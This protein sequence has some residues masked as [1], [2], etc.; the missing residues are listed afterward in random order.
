MTIAAIAGI[1]LVCGIGGALLAEMSLRPPRRTLASDANARA[2]GIASRTGATVTS[3]PLVASDGVILRAWSFAPVG[4]ARGT[5]ILVHGISDNRT[6]QLGLAALLLDHMYRVL[7]IDVRA[8]G[9]SGGELASY[10]LLERGDLR[11][12]TDWVRRHHPDE[13][14][15]AFGASMGAAIVL[16]TLPEEPY[17]AAIVEAPFTTFRETAVFRLG[18]GLHVPMWLRWPLLDPFV[19][20]GLLYARLRH[21]LAL[22]SVDAVSAVARAHVPLLVIEDGADDRVPDS[23]AR[24][25]ASINPRR[26]TLWT[27][28][29]AHHTQ[30]WAARPR[31]YPARILAFLEAHQ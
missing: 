2:S 24:R 15:F 18:S 17:C 5:A 19:E 27:I 28:P 10:G 12:W 26:V 21:G 9:S 8:H 7:A 13:C 6:S 29:D 16:Q 23:A 22:T 1:L 4:T 25:L 3:V 20:S 11:S 14:V 30:G 31:E